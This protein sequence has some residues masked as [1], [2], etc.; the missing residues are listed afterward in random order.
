MYK[1]KHKLELAL[2]HNLETVLTKGLVVSQE[3]P[4]V[5]ERRVTAL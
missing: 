2:D 1:I 5:P 4:A 3:E